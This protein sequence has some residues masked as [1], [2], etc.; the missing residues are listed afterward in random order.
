MINIMRDA[1]AKNCKDLKEV[2]RN[3]ENL[4][5]INYKWLVKTTFETIYN[6][7]LELYA[8]DLN[9]P[10]NQG[11]DCEKIS[12]V[13]NSDYE[14]TLLFLIPFN[15]YQPDAS[16]YLIT[17]VDYGS[18]SCCDTLER[19]RMYESGAPSEQ[20]VADFMK[21]CKDIVT[22]AIKPYNYGWRYNYAFDIATVDE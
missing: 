1:W 20:Q 13:N 9:Y 2:L 7:N 17:Y 5:A 22:N 6:K 10:Y 15:T 21:L 16:E 8:G 12:V 11:L 14:G 19:I 4:D 3:I 18:C